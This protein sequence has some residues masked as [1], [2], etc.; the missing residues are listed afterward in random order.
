MTQIFFR[1]LLVKKQVGNS[2]EF[3]CETWLDNNFQQFAHFSSYIF[4]IRILI[5]LWS[6]AL[7]KWVLK[8]SAKLRALRA[9][10]STRLTHNYYAPARLLAHTPNQLL[11]RACVPYAL[12]APTHLARLTRLCLVLFC[13]AT[14]ER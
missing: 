8:E 10:E 14:N 5:A 4:S 9:L 13:V 7:F 6:C 12:Y 11:T 1:K 3:V 2:L